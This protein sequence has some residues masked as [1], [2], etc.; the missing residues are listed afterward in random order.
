MKRLY[1]LLMALPM[2]LFVACDNDDQLPEVSMT[3]DMS[4]GLKSDGIIYMVQGDTL[5]VDSIGV[6]SL[7]G[8]PATLGATTYYWDT[9]RVGTLVVAP[10]S[11]Q[12]DT[13]DMPLGNHLLE[14]E[15]G[16]YQVDKTPAY[17]VMGYKVNIVKDPTDIP[18]DAVPLPSKPDNVNVKAQ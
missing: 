13:G 14:I 15:T 12:F 6:E 4:G 16:I 5:S 2:A 17:A 3:V 8:K 10:Y 7:T 11:I 9:F 18:S 1:Y